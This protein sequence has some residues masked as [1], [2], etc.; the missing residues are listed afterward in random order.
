MEEVTDFVVEAYSNEVGLDEIVLHLTPASR[1]EECDH[2]I[3]AYLQARL[4]VS[5]QIVYHDPAEMQKIQLPEVS[6]KAIKFIDRRNQVQPS[7]EK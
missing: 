2:R 4:R 1:S 7:I 3:R 6:R 5:P